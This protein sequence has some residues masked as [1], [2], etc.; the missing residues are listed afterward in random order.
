MNVD[1]VYY[2][3]GVEYHLDQLLQN[4]Q[5]SGDLKQAARKISVT[6]ANIDP[7]T[8]NTRLFNFQAGKRLSLF[9]DGEE[10]FRGVVFRVE[11]DTNGTGKMDAFD[12]GKYLTNNEDSRVVNGQTASQFIEQLCRE[13]GIPTGQI[14]D[15]GYVFSKH[16]I[17]EKSIWDMAQELFTE[18]RLE[19]GDSF[20]MPTIDGKV[21]ILKRSQQIVPYVLESN[22]NIE[23]VNASYDIE[24]VRN[25]IKVTQGNED[26][27]TGK[28]SYVIAKDEESIVA[29][30]LMQHIESIGTSIPNDRAQH[31]ANIVLEKMKR[32]NIVISVDSLGVK[33]CLAGKSVYVNEP[34]TGLYG[35]YYIITDMHTIDGN[36]SYKMTLDISPTD[37]LPF[38]ILPEEREWAI[39]KAKGSGKSK[40]PTPL[41]QLINRINYGYSLNTQ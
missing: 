3:D 27:P 36:G 41:D 28:Y 2:Q 30:G 37:D 32:P 4:V 6:Y 34:I 14:D 11:M 10:V 19:T 29:F 31:H 13:Y 17:R 8:W 35:P 20:W 23:H 7:N 22:Y 26:S 1:V 12:E 15:T 39:H 21:N 5:W 40:A 25:Q 24:E 33:E 16:I 38:I 18:T 9:L